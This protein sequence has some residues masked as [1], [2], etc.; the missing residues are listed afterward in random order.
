[1]YQW[2]DPE[3]HLPQKGSLVLAVVSAGESA[4][5]LV[6]KHDPCTGWRSQLDGSLC[7][8]TRVTHWAELDLVD[9][10]AIKKKKQTVKKKSLVKSTK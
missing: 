4:I 3:E 6:M 10:P 5:Y 8:E 1:M 7:D 9:S 2:I